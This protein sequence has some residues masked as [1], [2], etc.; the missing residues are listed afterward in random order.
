VA[1]L[2]TT[3]ASRRKNL[4]AAIDQAVA[5][6]QISSRQAETMRTELNRVGR[7]TGS[8]TISYPVAVMLAKDVDLIG[9]QYRTIVTTAPAYVPIING[10]QFTILTG[11]T[12]KLDDFS[13]RRAGLETRI[14]KDLLEGRLTSSRA[15]ELRNQLA[16]IGSEANVYIA[17]GGFNAKESRRLYDAFDHVESEIDKYG[18]KNQD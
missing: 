10:S 13:V 15:A 8:N 6:G 16:N 17:D 12:Y 14:T 3:I 9:T 18:G 11:Q 5:S 4:E 7:Q 2:V 1:P